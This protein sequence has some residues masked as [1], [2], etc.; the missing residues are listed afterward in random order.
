[1][2]YL[3]RFLGP[4]ISEDMGV[5]LPTKPTE[6][7]RESPGAGPAARNFS[8]HGPQAP[9]KTNETPLDRL[10]GPRRTRWGTWAW[11]DPAA[12]PIEWFGPPD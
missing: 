8:P 7:P 4:E 9:Y 1:V 10:R 6:P 2:K 3:A 5:T 12:P 11:S